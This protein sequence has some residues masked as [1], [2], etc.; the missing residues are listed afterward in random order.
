MPLCP[1]FSQVTDD[2]LLY[3]PSPNQGDKF[4]PPSFTYSRVSY[5]KAARHEAVALLLNGRVPNYNI[6]LNYRVEMSAQQIA[7][8]WQKHSSRLKRAGIIARVA[9]EITKNRWR[10][11]A[12]NRVHYHIAVQDERTPAQLRALVRSVCLCEMKP[13]SFRVTCKPITNWEKKDVWYFV[14]YKK[15]SNYLFKPGLPL[16]KFYVIN[17]KQWWTNKDGTPR[18]RESIEKQIQRYANVKLRLKKYERLVKVKPPSGGWERPTDYAKLQKVL[19]KQSDETLYDWFSVLQGK[20]AVFPDTKFPKWLREKIRSQPMKTEELLI[21]I[22]ERLR[23][24]KNSLIVYA[25]EIYH[26]HKIE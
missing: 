2:K 5:D 4:D 14:K 12:V 11:K 20:E 23:H 26:D 17:Q 15:L 7:D 3:Q 18:T 19:D 24:T 13:G 9:I 16:H 25:F 6:R 22:Y 1:K 10:T 8:L 21:A